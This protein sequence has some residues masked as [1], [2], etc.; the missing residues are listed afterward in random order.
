V[1]LD[2]TTDEDEDST[3]NGSVGGKQRGRRIKMGGHVD[4]ESET[5]YDTDDTQMSSST[6]TEETEESS[7]FDLD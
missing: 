4:G 3:W 2:D 7:E 1:G 6:F 5:S